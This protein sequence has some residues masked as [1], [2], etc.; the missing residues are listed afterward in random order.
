MRSVIRP[1][2]RGSDEQRKLIAAVNKAIDR[3]EEV[4]KKAEAEIWARAKAARDAGV[5]D[6]QLCKATGLN[7][8]TMNRILG[9]RAE[10]SR[11]SN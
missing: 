3:A 1:T 11:P 7:R 9:P 8:S 5:P 6:T 10:E 4:N 2:W